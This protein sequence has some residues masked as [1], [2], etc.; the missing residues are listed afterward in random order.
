MNAH[1][2]LD[3]LRNKERREPGQVVMLQD[4]EFDHGSLEDQLWEEQ[5]MLPTAIEDGNG[6]DDWAAWVSCRPALWKDESLI[7][8]EVLEHIG[9]KVFAY[10]KVLL[11]TSKHVRPVDYPLIAEKR[12]ELHLDL[13]VVYL[14]GDNETWRRGIRDSD[15]ETYL[16][17]FYQERLNGGRPWIDE[18]VLPHCINLP[19]WNTIK[20]VVAKFFELS[21]ICEDGLDCEIRLFEDSWDYCLCIRTNPDMPGAFNLVYQEPADGVQ[22]D[23]VELPGAFDKTDWA[24]LRVAVDRFFEEHL[25]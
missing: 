6:E 20:L 14:D 18:V 8:F 12:A 22:A 23:K 19:F 13:P 17:L 25:S 1:E 4:V 3:R 11:D 21:A 9:S 24:H 5:A 7:E 16:E 10:R 2:I 15:N